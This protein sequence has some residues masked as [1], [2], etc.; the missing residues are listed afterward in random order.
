MASGQC[1]KCGSE[2]ILHFSGNT[3]DRFDA[4]FKGMEHQGYVLSGLN[5]GGG[6]YIEIDVCMQ[7][8]HMQGDWPVADER[9]RDA[10]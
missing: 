7:C 1:K 6:D 10:I 2:S 8:G 9:V 3:S 5:I 4:T